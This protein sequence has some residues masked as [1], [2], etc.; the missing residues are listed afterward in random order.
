MR[1]DYQILLK[2]PSPNQTGWIRPCQSWTNHARIQFNAV[3]GLI[4]KF[5]KQPNSFV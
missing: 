4:Q 1:L 2:T 5:K 3:G